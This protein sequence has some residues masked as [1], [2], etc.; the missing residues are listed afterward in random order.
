MVYRNRMF[1]Q[2]EDNTRPHQFNRGTSGLPL[3][4]G[5]SMGY[6]LVDCYREGAPGLGRV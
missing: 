5:Y 6:H 4:A 3:W 2:G 1:L